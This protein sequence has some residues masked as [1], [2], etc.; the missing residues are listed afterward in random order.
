[1]RKEMRNQENALYLS[2]FFYKKKE[3]SLLTDISFLLSVPGSSMNELAKQ[4]HY[5]SIT[6]TKIRISTTFDM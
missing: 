5:H 3:F 4:T 6:R 1:M 2:P